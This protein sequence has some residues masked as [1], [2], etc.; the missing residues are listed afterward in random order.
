MNHDALSDPHATL[1]GHRGSYYAM[2]SAKRLRAARRVEFSEQATASNGIF[3][4]RPWLGTLRRT[5]PDS[6]QAAERRLCVT[7]GPLACNRAGRGMGGRPE[8]RLPAPIVRC[9][10]AA[11]PRREPGGWSRVCSSDRLSPAER[12]DRLRRL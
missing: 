8:A 2:L 10:F 1:E 4:G 5:R 6:D 3:G 7:P 11:V 12:A 9:A